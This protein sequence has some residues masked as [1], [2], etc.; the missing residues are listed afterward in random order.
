MKRLMYCIIALLLA[1]GCATAPIELRQSQ[2]V[3]DLPG[4]SKE[5]IFN[6]S[7]QWIAESF[8]S[9]NAVIQYKDLEEG[10]IIGKIITTT[11]QFM[12]TYNFNTT[13]SIDVKDGRAMLSFQANDV[14]ISSA[15]GVP[16]TRDI[17]GEA[18]AG[19]AQ[20]SFKSIVASYESYMLK[21]AKK[22]DNW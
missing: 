10:K 6:R 15:G 21:K 5:Q 17:Y 2:Q 13:M 20:E 12:T 11:S 9:A 18:E 7:N 3:V 22:D 8:G 16:T 14:T 1:A 19:M 4:M